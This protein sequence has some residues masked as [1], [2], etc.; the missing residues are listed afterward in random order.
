MKKISAKSNNLQ[1]QKKVK[2]NNILL[3]LKLSNYKF[4]YQNYKLR[5]I[6]LRNTCELN[7]VFIRE[8]K[9]EGN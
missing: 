6:K 1:V 9:W 8:Q 2:K 5:I 7:I 3:I 4:D